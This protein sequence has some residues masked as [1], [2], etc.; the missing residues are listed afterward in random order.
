MLNPVEARI[1]QVTQHG[2]TAVLLGDDMFDLERR[3]MSRCRKL[4][5]FAGMPGPLSNRLGR[6][7]IHDGAFS[8]RPFSGES[9]PSTGGWPGGRR[10]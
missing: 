5:V 3:G 1:G 6:C 4:A 9:E 7:L 10:P 8:L 2:W